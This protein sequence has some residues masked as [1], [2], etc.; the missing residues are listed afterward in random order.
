MIRTTPPR[1]VDVETLFPE[2]AAYR[3][4]AIRLHPRAGRPGVLDSSVGGPLLWPAGEPWPHCDDDHPE[5]GRAP[6]G[7]GPRPMVPVLQLLASDVPGLPFPEGTDVLQL[8]WCPFD[9]KPHHTPRPELRWRGTVA[10]AGDMAVAPWVEDAVDEY[11]PEPCLVHPERIVEYPCH[12]L[13]EDLYDGLAERFDR[14]R[15]DTGW[16][17][18]YHLSVAPGIKT[19]GHPGWTQD[20]DWPDCAE[21]GERMEHLLTVDSAEFDGE[22]WRSWLPAEDTPRTGTVRDLPYEERGRIQRAPGLM[23]GDMGGV[24]LFL[25]RRCPGMPYDYRADCS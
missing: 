4:E 23:L 21:C 15:R 7:P 18:Q 12:D 20:P 16:S 3:K 8:L 2:V 14:L 19:G 1:P 25:C 5:T 10:S 24:Y 11:V 13:P 9:H 6:D 22:S 17:Y